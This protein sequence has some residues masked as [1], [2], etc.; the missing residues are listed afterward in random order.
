MIFF[1][2]KIGPVVQKFWD[3]AVNFINR[4]VPFYIQLSGVIFPNTS[5]R[6]RIPQTFIEVGLVMSLKSPDTRTYSPFHRIRET[7]REEQEM[8]GKDGWV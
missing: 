1:F 5:R 7:F 4:M 6:C 8:D 2:Q 3:S